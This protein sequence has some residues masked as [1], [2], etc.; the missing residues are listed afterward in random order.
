MAPVAAIS[1]VC[2]RPLQ[3]YPGH[4]EPPPAPPAQPP[5]DEGAKR[6]AAV[7]SLS[8]LTFAM[9]TTLAFIAWFA[10]ADQPW[11][12]KA[13]VALFSAML[14]VTSSALVWRAPSRI[15]VIAGIVV[16]VISLVRVGPP[17]DWTWVSCTLLSVT[18]LLLVPLVHA[19]IVLR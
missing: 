18:L 16:M 10:R 6:A 3:N 12:W 7:A 8:L 17:W 13:A 4:Y 19:A 2:L 14:G 5:D 15:H 9:L 1:G 11:N